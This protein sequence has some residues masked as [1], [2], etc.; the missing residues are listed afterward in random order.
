M[1]PTQDVQSSI[2]VPSCKGVSF[3]GYMSTSP[4]VREL[5]VCR[6]ACP[7]TSELAVM[8][9]SFLYCAHRLPSTTWNTAQ[10]KA[11]SCPLREPT[12]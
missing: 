2:W 12:F 7:Y 5:P 1:T 3:P 4:G 11:D 6:C 8:A 10:S 9:T